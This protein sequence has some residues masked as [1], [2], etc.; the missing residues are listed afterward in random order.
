MSIV[1]LICLLNAFARL[2]TALTALV[3]ALRHRR[4]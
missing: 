1:S 4:R 3:R 2:L